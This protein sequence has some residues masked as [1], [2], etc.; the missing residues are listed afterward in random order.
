M[1][2]PFPALAYG[3]SLVLC[4]A[5]GALPAG[6][7][8]LDPGDLVV[9]NGCGGVASAQVLRI[10]P[11]SGAQEVVSEAGLLSQPVGIAIDES[12]RILVSDSDSGGGGM[13]IR[14]NP[15][16]GGQTQLATGFTALWDLDL[17]EGGSMLVTDLGSSTVI[18][19]VF[20]VAAAGGTPTVVSAGGGFDF[21]Q[22]IAVGPGGAVYVSDAGFG[23]RIL[24]VNPVTGGQGLVAAGF[25]LPTGIDVEP[26]G[27]IIVADATAAQVIRVNPGTGAAS[28]VS[29]GG[30]LA[31]PFGVTAAPSGTLFVS[32]WGDLQDIPAAVVQVNPTT[33]AQSVV[34]S[35]GFLDQPCGITTVP[36]PGAGLGAALAGA[37]LA[38][39]AARRRA[40]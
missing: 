4:A 21:L 29:V 22:S 26:S 3:L 16:T 11:A 39:L 13:V 14:I 30:E 1:R 25:G 9:V 8:V 24:S 2:N 20:R 6:A 32:D 35:G 40:A 17:E 5:G 7:V 34:S 15:A 12:G 23:G 38:A 18:D 33:G 27:Q 10:D 36:E 31:F 37:V 28:S 19:T